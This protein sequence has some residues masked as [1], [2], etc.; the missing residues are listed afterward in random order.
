MASKR[1]KIVEWLE[2]AQISVTTE[3]MTLD[4]C[5]E[6]LEQFHRNVEGAQSTQWIPATVIDVCRAQGTAKYIKLAG[7]GGMAEAFDDE[8]VTDYLFEDLILCSKDIYDNRPMAD[9]ANEEF[10]FIGESDGKKFIRVPTNVN[11]DALDVHGRI[12]LSSSAEYFD[13]ADQGK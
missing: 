2:V 11:E 9:Y 8:S 7:E 12:D 4:A 1:D 13:Y 10:V 3:G 6:L 5:D